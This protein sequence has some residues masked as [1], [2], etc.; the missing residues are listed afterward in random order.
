MEK[1]R[2]STPWSTS[3]A[4][5]LTPRSSGFTS[6]AEMGHCIRIAAAAATGA[7]AVVAVVAVALLGRC[8]TTCNVLSFHFLVPLS[9]SLSLSPF[10]SLSL[11]GCS[12]G[13]TPHSPSAFTVRSVGPSSTRIHHVPTQ[14]IPLF[15]H[16]VSG[17]L[18]SALSPACFSCL[19]PHVL[20]DLLLLSAVFLVPPA[21]SF[22][23]ALL[24]LSFRLS[25]AP[26]APSL[27]SR[28][29]LGLNFFFFWR[30]FCK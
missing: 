24:H 21:P 2:L 30:R 14:H 8:S 23:L 9:L 13:C 5:I 17:F 18:F 10:L 4:G 7:A 11:S 25:R 1:T 28:G 16:S 26:P 29:P 3:A 6:P 27:L 12:G 19:L 15:A 22:L 20:T